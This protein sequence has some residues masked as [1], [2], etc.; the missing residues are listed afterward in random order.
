MRQTSCMCSGST[1]CLPFLSQPAPSRKSP[2]IH[3]PSCIQGGLSWTSAS[4]MQTQVCVPYLG[5]F[6]EGTVILSLSNCTCFPE[7]KCMFFSIGT[8]NV[9]ISVWFL[10]DGNDH[11][12]V[13]LAHCMGSGSGRLPCPSSSKQLERKSTQGELKR[14]DTQH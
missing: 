14:T 6:S 13:R 10:Q 11:L 2:F 8:V 5:G 1:R 7:K 3:T 9:Y 4:Y 12:V